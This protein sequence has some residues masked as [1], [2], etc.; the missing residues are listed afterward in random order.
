LKLRK[1]IDFE[2]LPPY[3][4]LRLLGGRRANLLGRVGWET[5]AQV[6]L[7]VVTM[8]KRRL[9]NELPL[10]NDVVLSMFHFEN[11]Q[12]ELDYT[13]DVL[14]KGLVTLGGSLN[15]K[16]SVVTKTG[17]L[18]VAS[19]AATRIGGPEFV[20]ELLMSFKEDSACLFAPS[21]EH[22]TARVEHLICD[23]LRRGVNPFTQAHL[24]QSVAYHV[25]EKQFTSSNKKLS[26]GALLKLLNF[27][28]LYWHGLGASTGT[29][30]SS[31]PSTETFEE[32]AATETSINMEKPIDVPEVVMTASLCWRMMLPLSTGIAHCLVVERSLE[33]ADELIARVPSFG[34]TVFLRKGPLRH[35]AWA[36][37]ECFS[38]DIAADYMVYAPCGPGARASLEALRPPAT[39]HSKKD[40]PSAAATRKR[41]YSA[42]TSQIAKDFQ[43]D[44]K[45]LHLWLVETGKAVDYEKVSGVPWSWHATQSALCVF[46]KYSALRNWICGSGP[47]PTRM[48]WYISRK[49]QAV[50]VWKEHDVL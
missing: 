46:T 9:N 38:V 47:K 12:D 15:A 35:A 3:P 26:E 49:T 40:E 42:S 25:V 33:R 16:R 1:Q 32:I 18:W 7:E 4:D 31:T 37:A 44:L 6:V 29:H 24:P 36:S 43:E 34:G 10:T 48:R 2:K 17:G 30:T 14:R 41:K 19:A 20:D 27:S 13:T 28:M 8:H 11:P 50:P 22:L 45:A 23:L 21:P 5:F 39:K